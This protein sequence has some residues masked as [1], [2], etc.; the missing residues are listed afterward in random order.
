[1]LK[2][3]F[4]A[5]LTLTVAAWQ[6]RAVPT[7]VKNYELKDKDLKATFSLPLAHDARVK[8]PHLIS[9]RLQYP[10]M[11]PVPSNPYEVHDDE[12]SIWIELDDGIGRIESMKN[13]ALQAYD[14]LKPG[15][16]YFAG[17]E[18]E[19]EIYKHGQPNSNMEIITKI[20]RSFD[21]KE[22]A[23]KKVAKNMTAERQVG[24]K[25]KVRYLY[26]PYLWPNHREVDKAVTEYIT[27]HLVEN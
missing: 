25:F 2:L 12:I 21:N 18:G 7:G 6:E 3:V 15:A 4:L 14:P 11:K 26:S 19:Y 13:R 5:V 17:M 8:V 23:V 22:V 1:M 10:S 24:D 9:F 27:Q 20:F 16:Y